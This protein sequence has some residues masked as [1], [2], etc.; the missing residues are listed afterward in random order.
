MDYTT[1][2]HRLTRT[3]LC[4]ANKQELLIPLNDSMVLTL[5]SVLGK[6]SQFVVLLHVQSRK[7]LHTLVGN[8]L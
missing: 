6:H 4:C 7:K 3:V 5:V 1:D 2:R 8:A